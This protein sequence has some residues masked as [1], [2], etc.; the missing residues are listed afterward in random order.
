MLL[1]ELHIT[2]PVSWHPL[3]PFHQGNGHP[4]Y[5]TITILQ[6]YQ[7]PSRHPQQPERPRRIQ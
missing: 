1:K 6:S 2:R 5:S 3:T 7:H 4:N